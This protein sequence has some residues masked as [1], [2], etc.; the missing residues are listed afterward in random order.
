MFRTWRRKSLAAPRPGPH[1]RL[2]DGRSGA[3]RRREHECEGR[4]CSA[5]LRTADHQIGRTAA[6]ANLRIADRG[7]DI[8]RHR[9]HKV[10][11]RSRFMLREAAPRV[12]R[13][14]PLRLMP[15]CACGPGGPSH[16]ARPSRR[17]RRPAP[18]ILSGLWRR[19]RPANTPADHSDLYHLWA[20]CAARNHSPPAPIR[21][22]A[23]L[24]PAAPDVGGYVARR[25]LCATQLGASSLTLNSRYLSATCIP[26][27][28]VV[29]EESDGG[30]SC[31][32]CT[33]GTV[34]DG[35]RRSHR[36]SQPAGAGDSGLST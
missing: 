4:R 22:R 15:G 24:N 7:A 27:F 1:R 10:R 30:G 33:A 14:R 35:R 25:G 21:Q 34:A 26:R 16:R 32:V 31:P 19:W 8:C 29:H 12:A 20:V 28:A 11:G 9:R 36:R 13:W 18:A 23:Q 5:A 3:A 17:L 2:S 6:A